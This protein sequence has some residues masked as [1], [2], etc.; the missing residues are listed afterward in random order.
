M[1]KPTWFSHL[2][3]RKEVSFCHTLSQAQPVLTCPDF[4]MAWQSQWL[5]VFLNQWITLILLENLVHFKFR[6]CVVIFL[7]FETTKQETVNSHVKKYMIE[8][9]YICNSDKQIIWENGLSYYTLISWKICIG[10]SFI[11][12]SHISQL[13]DKQWNGPLVRKPTLVFPLKCKCTIVGK[14]TWFSHLSG[15]TNMVLSLK[16][17]NQLGFPT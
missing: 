5:L 9:Y 4:F 11:E 3:K 14:P 12:L 2:S 17:E 1:A 15:K 13:R 7:K 8:V 16:W 6:F 10:S